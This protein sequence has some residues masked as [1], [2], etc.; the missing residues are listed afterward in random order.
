MARPVIKVE[1]L[2]KTYYM[3]GGA[4]YPVLH[5][6]S[7]EIGEGEFVAIMGPS[8]SGKSTLMNTL[9]CLDR[10]TGGAYSIDGTV[11]SG[12]DSDRLAEVRNRKIGFVFQGFN[13]L[14][15][16]T[17]I[18]NVCIPMIYSGASPDEQRER[19]SSMLESVG[20]KGF[21]ER[22]PAQIS[23][24]MQQRVAIARALV[25]R[26]SII[27][28]DEPTGNLDTK[29]S[30]EIMGLFTDLNAQGKTIIVVTHEPDVAEYA[31]RLIYI[32]DGV[33]HYDGPVKGFRRDEH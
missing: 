18:D 17:I 26:P 29:T 9:G 25:N 12:M 16:R 14:M 19:A 2:Q 23:G 11:V 7:F 30:G 20:L 5:D 10:P 27:L 13:L 3:E 32:L 24:G 31:G 15:R 21:A 8:G 22:L 28:A 33:L 4:E 1:R 6:I